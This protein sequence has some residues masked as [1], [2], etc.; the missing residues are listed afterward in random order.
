MY[1]KFAKRLIDIIL[2]SVGI[3]L[4]SPVLL[5]TAIAIKIDSKGPVLFKQKRIGI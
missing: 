4:L 2:S 1:K 3:I 5:I